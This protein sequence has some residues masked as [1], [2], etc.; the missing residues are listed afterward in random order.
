[1]KIRSITNKYKIRKTSFPLDGVY[2]Y[3]VEIWTSIDGGKSYWYC[4]FGKYARTW[5]EAIQLV[6]EWRARA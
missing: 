3:S 6:A 5:K 1:M 2:N 4:G